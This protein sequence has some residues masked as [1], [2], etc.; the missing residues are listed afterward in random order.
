M[1]KVNNSNSLPFVED[2][3]PTNPSVTDTK[4]LSIYK[5]LCDLQ[6]RC[7]A[8]ERKLEL[9]DFAKA[10]PETLKYQA[11]FSPLGNGENKQFTPLVNEEKLS[12]EE[13]SFLN[14]R[15]YFH[16][17]QILYSFKQNDV[18]PLIGEKAK[19]LI[20]EKQVF[21]SAYL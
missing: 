6:D 21:I 3:F 10:H 13:W 4:P 11:P 18:S 17:K 7:R 9:V 19:A 2:S 8:L 12:E 15:M 1:D 5:I 20:K 14:I 16:K